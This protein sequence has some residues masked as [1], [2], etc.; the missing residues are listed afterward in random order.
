MKPLIMHF[1]PD[2]C[3]LAPL[4][5]KYIPQ[6][7]ISETPQPTVFQLMQDTKFHSHTKQMQSYGSKYFNT[8]NSWAANGKKKGL[9]V[10][11]YCK[12][13]QSFHTEGLS[14]PS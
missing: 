1:P 4:R 14:R 3:C 9:L 6:H 8:Q 7:P 2:P 5:P 11:A 13:L 10:V 12:V